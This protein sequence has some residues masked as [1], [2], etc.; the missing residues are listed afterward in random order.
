MIRAAPDLQDFKIVMV[1]DRVDLEEQLAG[2][3]ALIAGKINVIE[4]AADLRKRLSTD[5]SDVNLVMVHKF[6]DRREDLPESVALALG[7]KRVPSREEL[8]CGKS[9]RPYS[10]HGR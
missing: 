7:G 3:A 2:T 4:S 8:R 10:S 6:A 5:A 9:L 1:N